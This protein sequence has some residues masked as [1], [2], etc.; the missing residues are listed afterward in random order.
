MLIATE[1]IQIIKINDKLWKNSKVVILLNKIV[2][3]FISLSSPAVHES[4]DSLNHDYYRLLYISF[5]SRYFHVK[6][7]FVT[8]KALQKYSI[9]EKNTN[10]AHRCFKSRRA[11]STK[12]VYRHYR[13]SKVTFNN[14]RHFIVVELYSLPPKITNTWTSKYITSK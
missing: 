4:N 1:R 3:L 5:H 12:N 13:K 11:N 7:F 10:I 2:C 9:R 6:M 14:N 8:I